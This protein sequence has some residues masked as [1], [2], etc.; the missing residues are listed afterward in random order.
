MTFFTELKRR[1]VVRMAGL[2][3]VGAWL[4]VQVAGTVLPMFGAPDWLPRSV[5][6]LLAMGFVPTLIFSWVFEL[7]PEGLKRDEDVPPN[8]SIAPQTARRMDRMIIVVLLLALGYFT[9][10]KFLLA[11]RRAAVPGELSSTASSK[12]IAV[13][14]F[15]NLSSDKENAYFAD[16]IQDEI[17]TRLSKIA[18]LKVISRT[19]TQKYKSA[20][21][22]LREV[23]QQLGVANL[24]EGSVQKIGKAAHIN[25]Q[26]I[27]VAS[28]E[29]LWAESYNRKL[30]DIFAVEGEVAGA[31]AEALNAKL[32]GAEKAVLAQQPT[33][34]PAAY[35]AYLQGEAQYWRSG[36]QS[37]QEAAVRS[38]EEATRLDPQ[39][40]EAWAALSRSHSVL[41]FH[42]D[43]TAARRAAAEHALAEATR[44]RPDLA[45]T[46]LARGYF[47][48]WVLHDYKGAL[49]MMRHLRD[50]WPNN[51]EIHEVIAFILARLGHWQESIESIDR[52]IVLNPRDLFPRSQAIQLRLAIRDF[53][54]VLRLSDSALQIWPDNT[55]LRGVKATAFQALGRLDD[56]QSVLD[57]VIPKINGSDS[58]LAAIY[59]QARLRRDP[60]V[61]IKLLEPH[62]HGAELE[63]VPFLLFWADLQLM[64]GKTAEGRAL[65]ERGRDI[66]EKL[67]QEQP[68]N[69]DL[70]PS[71]AFALT[72]LGER[73]AALR[74]V[75]KYVALT[76][77]DAR[78]ESQAEEVRARVLARFGE[79]ERAISSVERILANPSDGAPPLT[80]ALLRLDPDFDSLRGDPRFQ[81]LCEEKPK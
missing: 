49:E 58:S 64:A 17:L 18:T 14:P 60:A 12:S 73:D 47:Q 80:A 9:V 33:N 44:L 22:N 30:D 71:L 19:S 3:L 20:P 43:A 35:D 40:A 15:E 37:E 72:E 8:Q 31:I 32:T 45:E 7:T 2:Y 50:S 54:S 41:F 1:N 24:L 53:S 38:F 66:L 79:K 26:L 70:I 77:G 36:S 57:G 4:L 52:V 28:D 10:D 23:G 65:F 25:V 5:V 62:T 39:F 51:P 78:S 61:A 16:G 42:S 75:D 74:T 46:Q 76:A 27:R 55:D 67:T 63:N 34:N 56:A 59:Y 48:Y 69:G 6:I 81:K 29:H 21:D 11:P 68:R 13:L